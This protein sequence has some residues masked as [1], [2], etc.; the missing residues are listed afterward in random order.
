MNTLTNRKKKIVYGDKIFTR[1]TRNGITIRDFVTEH[2]SSV[3]DLIM[4]VRKMLKD[5]KGLVVLH[6]RNYNGGWGEERPLM[7]YGPALCANMNPSVTQNI[8]SAPQSKRT[9]LFPWETH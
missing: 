7:L 3:T 6:I 4:E 5:I 1:V 2:V 8:D 9:M